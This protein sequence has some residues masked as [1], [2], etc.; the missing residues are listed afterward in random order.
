MDLRT[1]T[2]DAGGD[3]FDPQS[4][5]ITQLQNWYVILYSL[6]LGNNKRRQMTGLLN[7]SVVSL[8]VILSDGTDS[9]IYQ[10]GRPINSWVRTVTSQSLSCITRIEQGMVEWGRAIV[11]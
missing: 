3:G 9:S 2:H 4:S 6:V 7:V 1:A 5:Q 10:W 8:N 11:T